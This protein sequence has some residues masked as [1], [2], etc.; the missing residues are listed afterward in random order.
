MA[1]F[2]K[3]LHSHLDISQ[4]CIDILKAEALT[5]ST[6]YLIG[7]D[8]LF[9]GEVEDFKKLIIRPK[10]LSHKSLLKQLLSLNSNKESISDKRNFKSLYKALYANSYKNVDGEAYVIADLLEKHSLDTLTSALDTNLLDKLKFFLAELDKNGQ[11]ALFSESLKLSLPNKSLLIYI[12]DPNTNNDFYKFLINNSQSS[13]IYILYPDPQC[14]EAYRVFSDLDDLFINASVQQYEDKSAREVN[15]LNLLKSKLYGVEDDLV[16]SGLVTLIE[17]GGDESLIYS[18]CQKILNLVDLGKSVAVISTTDTDGQK[19]SD[20]LTLKDIKHNNHFGSL[21]IQD[22]Y[23]QLL[24]NLLAYC[25]DKSTEDMLSF[26]KALNK[27]EYKALEQLIIT[28]YNIKDASIEKFIELENPNLNALIRY[29]IEAFS[30]FDFIEFTYIEQCLEELHQ[31]AFEKALDKTQYQAIIRT[32]EKYYNLSNRYKLQLNIDE[33]IKELSSLRKVYIQDD[34]QVEIMPS[35]KI[36]YKT[37]D[38]VIMFNLNSSQYP[39][40]KGQSA[41]DLFRKRN[42]LNWSQE[43][44]K[45]RRYE[46]YKIISAAQ[47]GLILAK[48]NVNRAGDELQSSLYFNEV[49]D[50]YTRKNS[51]DDKDIP[52]QFYDKDFVTTY[53]DNQ[54]ELVAPASSEQIKNER[55]AAIR[56]GEIE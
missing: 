35:N 38:Y 16:A 45:I 10:T 50:L 47:E 52:Q 29:F 12:A 55:F 44:F 31:F 21:L 42:N 13:D 22:K 54:L 19:L 7:N 51:D 39:A 9:L 5:H 17:A 3:K 23:L 41:I 37:Y 43:F 11:C 4:C 14:H 15:E 2:V 46:F 8:L 36:S 25:K 24:L 20:L 48:L 18:V 6:S 53:F 40:Y 32:I 1:L 26:L 27:V 56:G 28:T 33:L 49:L 34:C 30:S